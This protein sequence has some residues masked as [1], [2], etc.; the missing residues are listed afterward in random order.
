MAPQIR[1]IHGAIL[2]PKPDHHFL[3]F[4][5]SLFLSTINKEREVSNLLTNSMT[6]VEYRLRLGRA[7]MIGKELRRPGISYFIQ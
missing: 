6:D 5:L 2:D 3:T 1:L 4:T 7:T